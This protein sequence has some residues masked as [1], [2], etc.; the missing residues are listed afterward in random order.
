MTLHVTVSEELF[1]DLRVEAA[2]HDPAPFHLQLPFEQRQ[3]GNGGGVKHRDSCE[4]KQDPA[5]FGQ[6]FGQL[7]EILC[8]TRQ[9]CFDRRRASL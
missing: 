4:I 9:W 8:A 2:Q 6:D 7:R 3:F 1:A 5:V